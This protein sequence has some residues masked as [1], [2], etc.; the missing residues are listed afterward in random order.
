MVLSG[1]SG[2]GR[3]EKESSEGER[4][5]GLPSGGQVL[6]DAHGSGKASRVNLKDLSLCFSPS[7][8]P[9]PCLQTPSTQ[10]YQSPNPEK[11]FC[12]EEPLWTRA[13][14]AF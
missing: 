3:K 5:L 13:G 8:G 14:Q 7:R 6:R 4:G 12:P 2:H 9:P 11:G 1:A 10:G